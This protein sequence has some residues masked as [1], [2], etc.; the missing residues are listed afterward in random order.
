MKKL[1]VFLTILFT[2]LF[3]ITC[4]ILGVDAPPPPGPELDKNGQVIE[5]GSITLFISGAIYNNDYSKPW[6]GVAWQPWDNARGGQMTMA[7]FAAGGAVPKSTRAW[8]FRMDLD[9][10]YGQ[11]ALITL[12][13]PPPASFS[14][15]TF[16]AKVTAGGLGLG[17][18]VNAD[19]M[20]ERVSSSG[21]QISIIE[22]IT[23]SHDIPQDG[24]WH[25][26]EVDFR[27]APRQI[28]VETPS[29][30]RDIPDPMDVGWIMPGD[31]ILQ[32]RIDVPTDAGR[33]YVDAI[34]LE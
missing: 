14:K 15:L 11:G 22:G 18:V 16:W 31:R 34:K 32:W 1:A 23:G 4:S 9:D 17:S 19:V 21:S 6:D 2:M 8:E 24:K 26:F 27:F 20:V 5:G 33:I 30:N 10:N 29:G 13:N 25:Q 7:S 28:T 3:L 12:M